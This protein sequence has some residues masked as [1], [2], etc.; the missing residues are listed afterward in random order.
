MSNKPKDLT[1]KY[2]DIVKTNFFNHL[3]RETLSEN[4]I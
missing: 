2:E 1:R 4:V 3:L